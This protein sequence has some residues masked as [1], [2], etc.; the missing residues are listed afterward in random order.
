LQGLKLPR[1]RHKYKKLIFVG[2]CAFFSLT[3]Q[4]AQQIIPGKFGDIGKTL[5]DFTKYNAKR[6]TVT[7]DLGLNWSDCYLGPLINLP[8]HFGFGLTIGM[9]A[10]DQAHFN[11][12]TYA[13]FFPN[14]LSDINGN[15]SI[16]IFPSAQFFPAY[17]VEARIGGFRSEHFDIG[18]RGGYLPEAV[19]FFD[20]YKYSNLNLGADIRFN[21]RRG[22][23][24]GPEMSLSLGVTYVK[25]GYT[26]EGRNDQWS[27]RPNFD[28]MGD[29]IFA[30]NGSDVVINWESLA[31]ELQYSVSKRFYIAGISL[32]GAVGIG[33]APV[34]KAGLYV[35]G[36]KF[37]MT[38][39]TGPTVHD[40]PAEWSATASA[41]KSAIGF[42]ECTVDYGGSEDKFG[43]RGTMNADPVDC[44]TLTG[45]GGISLDFGNKTYLQFGLLFDF[46]SQGYGISIGYRWQQ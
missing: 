42:D 19:S 21:I 36:D 24:W 5:R 18:V 45:A 2:L 3:L 9:N 41:L 10:I 30:L 12:L 27:N 46:L 6:M 31:F 11:D 29:T 35:L 38:G 34:N 32:Y 13:L 20:D 14:S 39:M 4:Y 22:W 40:V 15:L 28:E 7:G 1:L 26:I 23:G 17:S 43:M 33:Y 37:T 16:P 44:I 25:G 8:P